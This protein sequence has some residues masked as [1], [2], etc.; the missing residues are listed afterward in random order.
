LTFDPTGLCAFGYRLADTAKRT[1]QDL[2]EC[3]S[4]VFT[5]KKRVLSSATQ[6]GKSSSMA[7]RGLWCDW[8]DRWVV[9]YDITT[10]VVEQ[11]PFNFGAV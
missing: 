10:V 8:V 5:R 1:S 2:N 6:A 3:D 4:L 11:G 7:V 9:L